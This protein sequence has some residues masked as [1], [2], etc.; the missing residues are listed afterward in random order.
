MAKRAAATTKASTRAVNF[1]PDPA[2]RIVVLHGP[3]AFQRADRTAAIRAALLMAHGEVETIYLDGQSVR[4]ADVLDE[5]RSFGLLQQHKLIV[6]DA[7]DQLVKEDARPIFERYAHAPADSATLVLRADRWNSGRLDT[8]IEHAPGAI[9]KC[10]GLQQREAVPWA[11]RRAREVHARAIDKRA[12]ELLVELLGPDPGR[13]DS[14][15]AKLSLS[16]DDD[17]AITTALVKELVGCTREEEAWAIQADLLSG[18]PE[19]ALSRLRIVLENGPRDA[20]VPAQWAMLD[21]ARKLHGASHGFA[22]RI[23]PGQVMSVLRIWG[24]GSEAVLHAARRIT[25]SDAAAVLRLC[26]ESTALAR[27]GSDPRRLLEAQALRFASLTR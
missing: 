25:P 22:Q 23:A 17:D 26:V 10:D 19:A 2:A 4:P 5:C 6:A 11:E 14:E 7:A 27:S 13:I 15:L 12:A 21:L 3:D 24:A 1:R 20:D 9:V 8:L 18:D 16:V